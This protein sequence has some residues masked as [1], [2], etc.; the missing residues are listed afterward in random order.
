M[1]ISTL[2]IWLGSFFLVGLALRLVWVFYTDPIPLGGDPSWYV[3]VATNLVNGEGFV[4]NHNDFWEP[5]T[6]AQVTAFWPPGYPFALA[7]LWKLGG[8]SVTSATRVN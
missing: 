1:R 8:V 2:T 7:G 3:R 5:R 4:A 6:P